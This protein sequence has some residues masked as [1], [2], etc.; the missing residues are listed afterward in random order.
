MT[1]KNV[2]IKVDEKNEKL[3]LIETKE[4][5]LS[6][7]ENRYVIFPIRHDDIWRKYKEAESNFWTSEELDLT[8][9]KKDWNSLSKN[10]K[11]FIEM[12]LAFF[13]ASDGIVN[14]NL[15]ERFLNEIK[16]LEARFFYSFQVSMENIHSETYSLLIDTYIND[17][18]RK[19]MLFNAI[20]TIPS[21]KK[22]ADWALK[23]IND[24]DSDFGKRLIAFAVVEGIFF[25]GSFCSIFWLKK[26]GLMPGLCFSNELISRDEG[27]HTEFAVLMYKYLQNKPSDDIILDIIKEAVLIEKEF[28]MESLPCSLIGM[29]CLEM[30]T[31]IEYVADRLLNMFGIKKYY[32]SK[33]PFDWMESISIQGKTNF[34]ERRVGEYSNASNPNASNSK[35]INFLSEDF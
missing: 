19:H 33:N 11:Y 31:Y 32:N 4:F 2:S 30:S 17:N 8:K 34:F 7:E 13:A 14:E 29:N 27:L 1:S 22:K 5:L 3:T 23:W 25:S 28:T 9:D 35:D 24:K 6:E 21:I 16:V 15:V 12:T 26:R 18:D 20:D 10:E